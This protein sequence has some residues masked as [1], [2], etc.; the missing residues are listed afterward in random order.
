M[1]KAALKSRSGKR[2]VLLGLSRFNCEQLLA[3]RPIKIELQ[4]LDS[5]LPQM[6]LAIMGGETEETMHA[7]LARHGLI[8]GQTVIKKPTKGN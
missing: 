8:G 1:I 5:S 2:L 4:G 3:G 7:E 6:E